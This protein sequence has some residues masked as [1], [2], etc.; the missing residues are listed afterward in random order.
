[1]EFEIS[2][3]INH[4]TGTVNLNDVEASNERTPVVQKANGIMKHVTVV[5][6]L[7]ELKRADGSSLDNTSLSWKTLCSSLDSEV[8]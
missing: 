8:S 4:M 7:P 1:M 5:I 6:V 2:I 3:K